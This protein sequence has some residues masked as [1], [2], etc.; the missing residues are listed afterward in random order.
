VFRNGG[1]R[2]ARGGPLIC[3]SPPKSHQNGGAGLCARGIAQGKLEVFVP[4]RQAKAQS[5][6]T[7]ARTTIPLRLMV[8]S[9]TGRRTARRACLRLLSRRGGLT[10]TRRGY[11]IHSMTDTPGPYPGDWRRGVGDEGSR[12]IKTRV[13]RIAGQV[14]GIQRML[15]EGRYC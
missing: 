9:I 10:H 14:A 13:N 4:L 5:A 12:R 1:R 3:F 15:D 7:E 11:T 2:T 8:L 6:G